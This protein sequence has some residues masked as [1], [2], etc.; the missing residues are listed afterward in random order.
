MTDRPSDFHGPEWAE[1]YGRAMLLSKPMAI[2]R[3]GDAAEDVL[4]AASRNAQSAVCEASVEFCPP[5][6][7]RPANPAAVF[8]SGRIKVFGSRFAG[9]KSAP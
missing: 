1:A 8:R 9:Q 5:T 3:V 4:A 6:G 2:W 7:S